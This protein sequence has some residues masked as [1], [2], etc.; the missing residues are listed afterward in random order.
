MLRYSLL[1]ITA[2]AT[3]AH[4]QGQT[5]DQLATCRRITNSQERLGCYDRLGVAPAQVR[6]EFEGQG[7]RNT[8]PFRLGGPFDL[9]WES[10]RHISV[11]LRNADGSTAGSWSSGNVRGG[12]GSG[13]A[14][15]PRAGQYYVEV[16]TSG[17]WSLVAEPRQR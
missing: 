11:Y 13:Q 2:V 6:H 7:D 8:T 3:T 14:Y 1:V 17:T 10:T 4:A 12:P 9:R 15:W 5:S 16:V